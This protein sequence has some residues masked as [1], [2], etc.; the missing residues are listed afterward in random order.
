MA[1]FFR[2]KDVAMA[3]TFL[4]HPNPHH[5]VMGVGIGRKLVKGKVTSELCVRFYVERKLEKQAIPKEF[6]LP[7]RIG[8]VPTDVIQ[9]GRFWASASARKE[10]AF[11][12]PARPGCSVGFAFTGAQSGNLMAGTFGA[13]VE[14]NG[15]RFILSNNHVLANE[16]ALALGSNIFQPGLLDKDDPQHD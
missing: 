2:E 11:L 6:E 5:N 3:V 16:N 8:K 15:K 4:A 7:P 9:T 10:R 12:R 1:D 13:V 14:S